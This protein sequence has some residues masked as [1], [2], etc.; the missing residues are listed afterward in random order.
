MPS[1]F[2]PDPTFGWVFY[3]ALLACAVAAVVCDLRKQRL[4]NVLTVST[5]GFGLV[6][7]LVRGTWL[8]VHGE[9]GPYFGLT[10]AFGGLVEGLCFALAGFAVAFA[11][12]FVLWQMQACGAGDVKLMAA[13]GTW[14]GP[15]WILYVFAGTILAVLIV[16]GVWWG[17]AFAVR[18]NPGLKL[19]Y[20]LPV[21]LSVAPVMLWLWRQVLLR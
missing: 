8:G 7:N 21:F 20:A 18:K 9:P 1:T 10:G 15:L 13:V 16:M 5:F 17:Y 6:L 2:F 11:L 19:S 3:L 12:F 4:P 14:V